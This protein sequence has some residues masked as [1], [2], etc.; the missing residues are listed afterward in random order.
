MVRIDKRKSAQDRIP[1]PT[2]SKSNVWLEDSIRELQGV[3]EPIHLV[4]PTRPRDAVI[5]LLHKYDIGRV[6]SKRF[7]NALGPITTVDSTDAFVDVVGDDSE[8]HGVCSERSIQVQFV[9]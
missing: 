6:M 4:V 5:H 9:I 8:K 7:C 3:T 2:S 1:I